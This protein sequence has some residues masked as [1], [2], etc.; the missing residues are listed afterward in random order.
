[1]T[2]LR[3]V[4]HFAAAPRQLNAAERP[5]RH[6]HAERGNEYITLNTEHSPL[7]IILT[8]PGRGAVASL[9]L[10]G[11]GGLEI[12]AGLFVARNRR[13]LAEI[14]LRQIAVGRLGGEEVVLSRIADDVIE[15]HCHGGSA[16]V[17][18]LE[19]LLIGGGCRKI[20]WQ[21]WAAR[22]ES[23]QFAADALLAQAEA[24]TERTAA[25][26]LDQYHGALRKAFDAIEATLQAGDAAAAGLQA[27]ALLA[28]AATGLHLVRPWQ[29]VVAGRPNV[30]KSSLINAI[31]GY[32]RAIVHDLPGTTRDI[33]GIQTALDGWPVEIFDTAGLRAAGDPI[34]QAGIELAQ[35]KI[36]AADLVVLVFDS[37]APWTAAD[38]NLFESHPLAL[39][40]RNKT[41]L[42]PVPGPHPAG[43]N[44]SA[45]TSAGVDELCRAIA[46]RLVPQPPPSGAAVPF[47]AEHTWSNCDA[48]RHGVQW[49]MLTRA[50]TSPRRTRPGQ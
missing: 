16:A 22:Q 46:H 21:E 12:V 19:E 28:H 34:E 25:I 40:V 32:Q 15:L 8:P 3:V 6:S 36:A 5:S 17:A 41:D 49:D 35:A 20:S 4:T 23:D 7:L 48:S 39:L 44:V 13:P 30:G 43:M 26:L 29:V 24:R 11:A 14:P 10:E 9:R 2:T 37:S 38:Q 31:A 47:L 33:V 1:M 45:A 18:R 42:P 27:E 50:R